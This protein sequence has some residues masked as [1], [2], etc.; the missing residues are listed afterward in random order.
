MAEAHTHPHNQA[1]G[2]FIEVGGYRQPAPAP[3][4]GTTQLAAPRPPGSVP[5]AEALAAWDL[6]PADVG[7]PAGP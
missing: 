4:F 1:R 3:R 2:A 7:A 6:T 5:L